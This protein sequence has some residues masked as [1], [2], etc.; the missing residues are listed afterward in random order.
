MSEP[1]DDWPC[2]FDASPEQR[3]IELQDSCELVNGATAISFG[4]SAKVEKISRFLV[5]RQHLRMMMKLPSP[6]L[7]LFL[8]KRY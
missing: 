8:M 6:K 4:A 1:A 2:K 7:E 3:E 5:S